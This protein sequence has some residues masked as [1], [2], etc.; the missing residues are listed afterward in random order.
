MC[1]LK[2]SVEVGFEPRLLGAGISTLALAGTVSWLE[3]AMGGALPPP[4]GG[5]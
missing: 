2:G 3:E 5:T 1:V 4:E